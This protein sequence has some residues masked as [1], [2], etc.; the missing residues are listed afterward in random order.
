MFFTTI[1]VHPVTPP[2]DAIFL[3]LYL[4][5]SASICTSDT[6]LEGLF[7]GLIGGKFISRKAQ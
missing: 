4:C 2:Y 6:P 3:A 7:N 1:S 5:I